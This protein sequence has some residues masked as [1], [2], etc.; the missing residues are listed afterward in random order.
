VTSIISTCTSQHTYIKNNHE[1]KLVW[2]DQSAE[3]YVGNPVSDDPTF[4]QFNL[5]IDKGNVDSAYDTLARLIENAAYD[6][7]MISRGRPARA[8]LNLPM[9]PWSDSTCRAL[10]AHL[11]QLAKLRQSARAL[12][13][14]YNALCRKKRRSRKK[15]IANKVTNLIEARDV[16]VFEFFH[17]RK[18]NGQT[19]I[20]AHAWTDN[21][22]EHF[23]PKQTSSPRDLVPRLPCAHQAING[24]SSARQITLADIAIPPGPGGR[25]R[26]GSFIN[27]N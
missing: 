26:K 4:N 12:K 6:A 18:L 5:A 19:P 9:P 14:E 17:E 21:L 2:K 20:P 10:E 7:N 8:K 25:Y 24:S 11:Q 15:T 16:Q 3:L 23:T 13:K 27:I 1:Q 22:K